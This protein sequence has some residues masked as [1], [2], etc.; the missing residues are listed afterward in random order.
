[1]LA[2]QALSEVT[3]TEKWKHWS[4]DEQWTFFVELLYACSSIE[5][6]EIFRY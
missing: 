5:L 2:N 1:M 6:Y 4:R 3:T